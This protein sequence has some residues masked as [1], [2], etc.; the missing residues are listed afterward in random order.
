PS[1]EPSRTA[2]SVALSPL[3]SSGISIATPSPIPTRKPRKAMSPARSCP[4]ST[5][6]AAPGTVSSVYAVQAT[7][8]HHRHHPWRQ[9][10]G[11]RPGGAGGAVVVGVVTVAM[12]TPGAAPCGAGALGVLQLLRGHQVLVDDEGQL[13]GQLLRLLP[14]EQVGEEL[15]VG[16]AVLPPCGT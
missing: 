10:S 1:D 5:G 7:P 3:S 8:S 15:L 4:G 16:H 14:V 6:A 13:D 11:Y 12:V 9:G 2:G